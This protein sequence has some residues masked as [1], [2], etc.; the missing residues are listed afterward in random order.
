MTVI[1]I[2]SNVFIKFSKNDLMDKIVGGNLFIT[3]NLCFFIFLTLCRFIIAAGG[4]IK[5][6]PSAYT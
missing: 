6:K 1:Y 2:N 4:I 3:K 5:A